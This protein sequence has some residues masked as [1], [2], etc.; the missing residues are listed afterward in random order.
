MSDFTLGFVFGVFA[1]RGAVALFLLIADWICG[2]FIQTAGEP[3]TAAGG[4]TQGV[5][6]EHLGKAQMKYYRDLQ[7]D[8]TLQAGWALM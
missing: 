5:S 1:G 4:C 8:E 6:F 2:L 7:P 3:A